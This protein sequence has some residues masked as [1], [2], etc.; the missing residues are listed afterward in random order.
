MRTGF[1]C[2][3][4]YQNHKKSIRTFAQLQAIKGKFDL[5]SYFPVQLYSIVAGHTYKY[6]MRQM[7]AN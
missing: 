7:F 2:L 4:Y 1:A 5:C 3:A 6:T